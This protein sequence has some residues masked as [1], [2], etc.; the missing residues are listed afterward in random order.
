MESVNGCFCLLLFKK[1][2]AYVAENTNGIKLPIK[3]TKAL[4]ETISS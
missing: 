4:Q 3:F 2:L 1:S